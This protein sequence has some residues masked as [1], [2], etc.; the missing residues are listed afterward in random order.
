MASATAPDTRFDLRVHPV[1]HRN[2]LRLVSELATVL[3]GPNI[4]FYTVGGAPSEYLLAENAKPIYDIDCVCLINPDLPA[5]EH[6]ATR[7]TAMATA[8]AILKRRLEGVTVAELL[9]DTPASNTITPVPNFFDANIGRTA[10]YNP[11]TTHSITIPAGSPLT[12]IYYYDAARKI[13]VMSVLYRTRYNHR[14]MQSLLDISF[15]AFDYPGLAAKW[16]ASKSLSFV[17]PMPG[18]TIPS[19]SAKELAANQEYAASFTSTTDKRTRRLNR[20][21]RLR[22]K[23]PTLGVIAS[24]I[25]TPTLATI[26]AQAITGG[27]TAIQTLPEPPLPE[28]SVAVAPNVTIGWNPEMGV[29]TLIN[30][31]TGVEVAA[32][33]QNRTTGVYYFPRGPS[34]RAGDSY[35]LHRNGQ[36]YPYPPSY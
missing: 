15:P 8:A 26:P 20:A 3:R 16:A 9:A 18:M 36:F 24:S 5:T 17:I 19:L 28:P 7:E 35:W 21:A 11:F 25:S 33:S 12:G 6:K 10:N 27:G 23:Y 29:V 13:Y 1:Y 4:R 31:R 30:H 2:L 32:T 14:D 22:R 34:G